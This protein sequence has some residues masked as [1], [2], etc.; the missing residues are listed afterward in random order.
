MW[1][2]II[3][4]YPIPGKHK[5]DIT[6]DRVCLI[7]ALIG[8]DIDINVGVVI[9]SSLKKERYHQGY[10]YGFEGLLTRFLQSEGVEEEVLY[11]R[12]VVDT[13][14]IDVSM[15]IGLDMAHRPVLTMPER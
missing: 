5:I 3:C 6:R 12:T 13:C 4:H 9:L 8:D 7:Y 11:Y 1:M 15:T 10:K 2:K 14:P